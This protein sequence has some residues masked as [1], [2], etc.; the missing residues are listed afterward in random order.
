MVTIVC[1]WNT[2]RESSHIFFFCFRDPF[3]EVVQR[4]E[5]THGEADRLD[6]NQGNSRFAWVASG[7]L[8]SVQNYRPYIS[9]QDLCGNMNILFA[10]VFSVYGW[11]SEFRY[12][13]FFPSNLLI[14]SANGNICHSIQDNKLYSDHPLLFFSFLWNHYVDIILRT[15]W[16]CE[17]HC[18][19][20]S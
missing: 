9:Y 14:L 19:Q 4:P 10:H 7:S 17:V 8:P 15:Q 20:L 2:V 11:L 12:F 1:I 16:I 6:W 5:N 3:C 18:H 13:R